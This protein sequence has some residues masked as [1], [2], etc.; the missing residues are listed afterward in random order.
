MGD[1]T[2]WTGAIPDGDV[3]VNN[4]GA[5]RA[6]MHV[7][8]LAVTDYFNKANAFADGGLLGEADATVSFDVVWSGPVSRSVSVS[9]A[10]HGFVGQYFENQVTVTWS[11]SN[12]NGFSFTADPGNSSTSVPGDHFAEVGGE[13]NGVPFPGGASLASPLAGSR[14]NPARDLAFAL[15]ALQGGDGAVPPAPAAQ[16]QS[17]ALS[18]PPNP[19]GPGDGQSLLTGQ[20]KDGSSGDSTA[21]AATASSTVQERAFGFVA[22]PAATATTP[23]AEV[24]QQGEDPLVR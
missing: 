15:L 18:N 3:Q 19:A 5:G 14:A 11:G 4:L 12:E 21:K 16:A 2:F 7:H 8:D 6:E 10:A 13:V 20:L 1:R 22:D 17:L 24:G 9:D 23:F